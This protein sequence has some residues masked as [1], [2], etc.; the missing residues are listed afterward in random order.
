MAWAFLN[1]TVAQFP[2]MFRATTMGPPAQ[3]AGGPSELAELGKCLQNKHVLCAPCI[4][5]AQRMCMEPEPSPGLGTER[6]T[7]QR[8]NGSAGL[9][10]RLTSP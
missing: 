7:L 1:P 8:R 3:V 5:G 9:S 10:H 2:P 4:A 6:A